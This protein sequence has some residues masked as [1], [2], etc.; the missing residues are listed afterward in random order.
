M[1]YASRQGVIQDV[2]LWMDDD[3]FLQ[4]QDNWFSKTA[5]WLG[6]REF[7]CA[8]TLYKFSPTL[9]QRKFIRK[10][11]WCS[12]DVEFVEN[13]VFVQGGFQL[14]RMQAVTSI[15]WPWY[16][17][18]HCGGDSLLGEAL[19]HAKLP[20]LAYTDGYTTN[21]DLSGESNSSKRR[22][23]SELPL[24]AVENDMYALNDKQHAPHYDM[25]YHESVFDKYTV[26][27]S[28]ESLRWVPPEG[29]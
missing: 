12:P 8:G 10:Q 21:A 2:A 25:V 20:V 1:L 6:G 24:G 17:L 11:Q 5:D 15:G 26:G 7:G 22:G 16:N 29:V 14:L 27:F 4:P 13:R 23:Y 19:A 9:Q 18:R 28:A 3:S